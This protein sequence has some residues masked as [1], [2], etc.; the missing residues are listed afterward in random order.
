MEYLSS[1]IWL[2]VWPIFIYIVY[3]FSK[4]NIKQIEKLEK[5]EETKK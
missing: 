4:L 5:L 1:I 3:A 2:I